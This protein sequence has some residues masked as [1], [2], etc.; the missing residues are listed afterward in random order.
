MR[1]ETQQEC[2]DQQV[3]LSTNQTSALQEP[4]ALE[5][6]AHGTA[7]KRVMDVVISGTVFLIL[8]PVMILIMLLVKLTSPGSIFF[9]WNVIGKGGQPFVGHKFRTMFD[10]ADRIR[11]QLREKNEMTG[12]FF[13]MQNDPRVTPIGRILRRF[14]LDELPQLWSVLKGDMSLVG[15]RPTQIFEY[16]QLKDW[17][18][19]R[20]QVK[21]GSVSLWIVSGKTTDFD[22]MVRLDLEYINNWSMWLDLKILIKAIPYVLLG[23]NR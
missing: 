8:L 14:S 19:Q 10:G 13:K 11:E 23:K 7:M 2:H 3:L 4:K 5:L 20:V 9:R 6:P 1:N 17:Q 21:P 15:P 22:R 12:V 16:E 18:K